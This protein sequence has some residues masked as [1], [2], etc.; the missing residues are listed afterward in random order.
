MKADTRLIDLNEIKVG[1]WERI[2]DIAQNDEVTL[3][4]FLI[5][6]R[7]QILVMEELEK[8]DSENGK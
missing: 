8:G 6:M 4:D 5:E 3:K 2:R 1:F 7:A